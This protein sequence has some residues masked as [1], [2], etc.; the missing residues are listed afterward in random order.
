MIPSTSMDIAITNYQDAC[1]YLLQLKAQRGVALGLERMQRLVSALGHP[2]RAVP[3][4]HIA[5]TNGKGSVAAMVEAILRAAGWKTGLYTSPHLVRLGERIQVD[6]ASL[7]QGEIT[8]YVRELQPVVLALADRT[9]PDAVPSYFEFMTAMAFLHFQRVAC[10]VSV[11][12]VGLGGR[13]DA[14]NVVNPEVSVIT[15]IGLDHCHFLGD[16]IPAI[17]REKGGIIK[18]SRPVVMGKVPGDAAQVIEEVATANSARLIS[19]ERELGRELDRLPSTNLAGDFQRWNAATA[20]LAVKALPPKWRISSQAISAGLQKVTWNARWQSVRVGVRTVIL[21]SSHNAEGS[22]V[23]DA[24]LF[25]LTEA[26]GRLPIVIVGVLGLDRARPLMEVI[27]RRARE[28][29]LVQPRQNRA[30]SFEEL[31][32]FAPPGCRNQ[33]LR[34]TV[35]GIFPLP[36][37]CEV[38]GPSDTIVV[39]GSIYLAGEV[40]AR[41]DPA[42]GPFESHLQDF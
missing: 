21:D 28:I 31:A 33:L 32:S 3:C 42:H 36:G 25:G 19:V 29:H 40:L 6:R 11:I 7:S 27:C 18:P 14:T 38:G 20:S 12:E 30:C 2:E 23:L 26:T 5:G 4:I 34:S 1:L 39:T 22:D 16:S 13:L 41:L 37:R 9:G 10:D 15:S 8:G 24:S 35:E 17:A